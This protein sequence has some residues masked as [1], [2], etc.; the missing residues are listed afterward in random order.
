MHQLEYLLEM[1]LMFDEEKRYKE[2]EKTYTSAV[3]LAIKA[4]SNTFYCN[5]VYFMLQQK[6]LSDGKDKTKVS[7]IT[8]L[9]VGR[10]L[11]NYLW[12]LSF[13]LTCRLEDIQSLK[14]AE[15]K[16][17]TLPEPPKHLPKLKDSDSD[18]DSE[19]DSDKKPRVKRKVKLL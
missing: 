16:I 1:A 7:S 10:Y 8:E 5:I 17:N 2:A 19:D 9:A 11:L 15:H 18:G 13:F 14:N 12:Y 3:E 6:L 4:V